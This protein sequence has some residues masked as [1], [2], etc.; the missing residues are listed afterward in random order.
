MS[1]HSI[2]AHYER[3][4]RIHGMTPKGLDWPND[5][6]LETR[7]QTH[8]GILSGVTAGARPVLLDLGCGPGLLLDHMQATSLLKRVSYLGIDISSTMIAAARARWPKQAFEVRDI[9][10]DPLCDQAVD[11]VVA[12]GV[13]TKRVDVS[14]DA[15][16]SMARDLISSAYR[17]A[18]VG[19]SFNVMSRHVDWER[20]DLFH[21]G[22]DEVA[23]FLTQEVSRHF[24][25]R[26][27]YGLYEF[28]VFVWRE[29][30]RSRQADHAFS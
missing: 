11:V 15:M 8:L 20:Y 26:A 12:N 24:T 29:P 30:Q 25:I 23:S 10:T 5:R 3:C 1:W 16:V 18:R 27:D 14:H 7:F 17:A 9:I 28:T 22:F 21:W 2:Q 6:D 4:L 13:L 19:I